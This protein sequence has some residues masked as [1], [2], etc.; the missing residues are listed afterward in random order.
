[1]GTRCASVLL[2]CVL[3]ACGGDKGDSGDTGGTATGGTAT[4]GTA[5]GGT[6]TGGT[7]D[8]VTTPTDGAGVPTYYEFASGESG[9]SSVSYS[10]Q[11]FRQLLIEDM[12]AYVSGMTDRLNAGWFPVPG[13]VTEDMMFYLEF[14]STVGGSIDHSFTA[15]LPILQ[16]TYDDVSSDKDLFGKMAGNDE[17]G[18][19]KD[20][21]VDFVGWPAPGVT[22][23]ESLVRAWVAMLDDAAVNWSNGDIPT[24]PD[25]EPVG[26]V[27]VTAE[28]HDLKQLLEKFTRGAVAFSQGTDDYLDDDEPGK[29][30]LSDHT[31]NDDGKNYTPLEHQWD[32]GFGY[33]G[34]TRDYYDLSDDQIADIGTSDYDGDGLIDL[35]Y[36]VCWG[37]S[38][39]AAKRD[40]GA[41][42]GTDFT[43]Q[44]WE[45]FAQGRM[46]I[47][48]N[49]GGLSD[50]QFAELQGHRDQAV[51]AWENAIASTVVHYINDTLQ[52]MGD[53]GTPDYS[54]NDHAKHWGELKGFALV[55]QFNPRSP[56]SDGDF[57]VFHGL[58][59]TAPVVAGLDDD[60][61]DDLR[62]ARALLGTA[63][64]F[65]EANLGD[66]DG[67]NGW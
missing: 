16:T 48:E 66:D 57:E 41:V 32:E 24:G 33:F 54:F 28:G 8:T 44:A 5:T 53:Y 55:M 35:K 26:A 21:S 15:D 7:G 29:G 20:W 61:A 37:H 34:A 36:E 52:D 31:A 22:T 23:P 11:T 60:Y 14:D 19:H 56:M 46:L 67:E 43:K 27:Y 62:T 49:Y 50:D 25:G 40:R 63:Y 64:G 18:Q 1:M 42:V 4:G 51:A 10:G 59:G 30:L 38:V 3:T 13:E 65:D 47:A 6:A 58:V 45:A 9:A 17:V 2:A 12:T 39:N